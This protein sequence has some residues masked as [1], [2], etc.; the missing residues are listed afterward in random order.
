[1]ELVAGGVPGPEAGDDGNPGG[2]GQEP[3]EA[4]EEE[5]PLLGAV[6]DLH[7]MKKV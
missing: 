2:E 5:D 1:M 7:E 4:D 3:G 6:L